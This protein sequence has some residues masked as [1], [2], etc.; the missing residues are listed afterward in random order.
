M[1][2]EQ[3]NLKSNSMVSNS[4]YYCRQPPTDRNPILSSDYRNKGDEVVVNSSTNQLHHIEKEDHDS[5]LFQQHPLQDSQPFTTIMP[6]YKPQPRRQNQLLQFSE[7]EDDFSSESGLTD[8]FSLEHNNLHSS[9]L[10]G[11]ES[12]PQYSNALNSFSPSFV[13]PVPSFQIAPPLFDSPFESGTDVLF[14]VMSP[15]FLELEF[16][17]SV[18]ASR[19]GSLSIS[20]PHSQQ[21]LLHHQ[22]QLQHMSNSRSGSQSKL[23]EYLSPHSHS[24][25]IHNNSSAPFG[26]ISR[27]HSSLSLHSQGHNRGNNIYSSNNSGIRTTTP[28]LHPLSHLAVPD[29]ETEASNISDNQPVLSS[30]H[31][32]T[33]PHLQLHLQQHQLQQRQQVQQLQQLSVEEIVVLS[34]RDILTDAADHSLKAVELANTLRARVGTD[35]LANI[36]ERWGGLLALLECYQTLFRVDR[37]PKNDKVTLL[38][39]D[40]TVPLPQPLPASPNTANTPGYINNNSNNNNIPIRTGQRPPTAHNSTHNQNPRSASSQSMPSLSP[41]PDLAVEH[42]M[43]LNDDG[44]PQVPALS[45]YNC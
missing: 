14:G 9:Q 5:V 12:S 45:I 13:A 7:Y 4:F 29:K 34:C 16:D 25:N 30:Y 22:Q 3:T 8:R 31:S 38:L 39:M 42:A 15:S 18:A 28:S 33:T 32:G 6:A 19:L 26:V 40:N 10:N 44:S 37:I 11:D 1:E 41:S 21:R 27:P 2:L 20:R 36:R 35:F 17:S 24:S 43:F 23:A